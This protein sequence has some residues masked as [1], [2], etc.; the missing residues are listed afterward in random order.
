MAAGGT[1]EN[2]LVGVG[3]LYVAEIGTTEPT[4]ASAALPSANWIPIGYTDQGHEFTTD[5]TQEPVEVAEEVDPIR[6]ENTRRISSVT[7][8]M[9]EATRFRLAIALGHGA[10]EEDD[11]TPLEPPVAGAEVGVMIVWDSEE[12]PSDPANVRWIYRQ[13]KVAGSITIQHRKSPQKKLIPVTFNLEKP[14][15]L[16]S[17]RVIPN[18][19]GHIA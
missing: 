14:T 13:C 6:Y 16:N 12:D 10:D 11:A 15:G 3:R 4:S 7:F 19:D 8:A 17:F 1:S 2:V 5:V 18:A 9:A